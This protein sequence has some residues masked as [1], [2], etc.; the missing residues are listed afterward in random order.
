MLRNHDLCVQLNEC[1][2]TWWWDGPVL[3]PINFHLY[4]RRRLDF[5]GFNF[6][7]LVVLY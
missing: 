6:C 7:R 2:G 5:I 1:L 3:D 4:C